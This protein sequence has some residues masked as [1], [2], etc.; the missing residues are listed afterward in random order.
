[1]RRALILLAA[2]IPAFAQGFDIKALDRLGVNAKESTNITLDGDTLKMASNFLGNDSGSIKPLVKNLKGI[3]VRSFEFDK[4]GQYNQA[5]L[6]P[7]RLYLKTA[8]WIKIVDVKEAKET[9]EIYLQPLPNNQLG[10]LAII[11]AEATE[12]T[13]VFITGVMN[14]SDVGKLSGNMGIPN[15]PE[16]PVQRDGKKPGDSK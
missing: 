2:A 11:S 7:L 9:S 8:R 10:G 3:Y 1:M 4:P 16:I 14:M 6:A 12:V 5:D 15:L 13:V